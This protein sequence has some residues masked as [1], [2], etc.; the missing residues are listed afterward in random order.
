M[1]ERLRTLLDRLHRDIGLSAD[2]RDFVDLV[3]EGVGLELDLPSGASHRDVRAVLTRLRDAWT[4]GS[5]QTGAALIRAYK[6][7]E[8]NDPRMASQILIAA[9]DQ[10]R[11]P[12]YTAILD[13]ELRRIEDKRSDRRQ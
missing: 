7:E 9:R 13:G 11:M 12:F 8:D 10:L 2:E 3:A 4:Q 5:R 1:A 6:A